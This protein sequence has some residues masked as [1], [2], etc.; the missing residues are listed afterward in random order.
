[1]LSPL[2]GRTWFAAVTEFD[3]KK[4]GIDLNEGSATSPNFAVFVVPDV[5]N[6]LTL[7]SI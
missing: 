4:S 1:M 6:V 2:Q 5:Y 7:L 3:D